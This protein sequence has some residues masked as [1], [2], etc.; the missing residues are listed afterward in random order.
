LLQ[1]AIRFLGLC[2]AFSILEDAFTSYWKR[3]ATATLFN[4]TGLQFETISNELDSRLR[5]YSSDDELGGDH[6]V[7]P[8]ISE[9]DFAPILE[10]LPARSSLR[11]KG[12]FTYKIRRKHISILADRY[13]E[14]LEA[15]Y[16]TIPTI[17]FGAYGFRDLI[18]GWA[19][20]QAVSQIHKLITM[21]FAK[22]PSDIGTSFNWPGIYRE[23]DEWLRWF[24]DIPKGEAVMNALML[25]PHEGSA[26]VAVTPIIPIDKKYFGLVPS[27]M[28][29]ANA[30]RNLLVLTA[31]RFQREYSQYTLDR[32]AKIIADFTSHCREHV[33]AN[34]LRLP[35][36]R[37]R[38]LPDIDVLLRGVT[39]GSLI[40]AEIKWQLSAAET[41]EVAARN[42]YLKKG[43]NQLL[44]IKEFLEQNPNYLCERGLVD[45][46]T[47]PGSIT[48]LLLCKG[49][50]GS[51][52]VLAPHSIM[53]DYDI[54]IRYLRES[55]FAKALERVAAYDYLPIPGKDFVLGEAH[56]KFGKWDIKWKYFHPPAL[57][58]DNETLAL[59]RLCRNKEILCAT[60]PR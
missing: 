48:C 19:I 3:Y 44:A 38:Q 5:H 12:G 4:T 9:Q 54:F 17:Q 36:F 11:R 56:V 41:K 51:A 43:Q 16:G 2:Q 55:S 28:L 46:E 23:R 31:R 15:S 21:L 47:I 45:F 39:E 24:S 1:R 13:A 32:E 18:R 34:S 42:D 30:P 25:N 53:A 22:D 57:I 14:A 59:R 7:S 8:Q 52:D 27:I 35:T 50:L 49:H 26:D 40:I 29:R 6:A 20:L 60:R 33:L 37:G 58:P 10:S